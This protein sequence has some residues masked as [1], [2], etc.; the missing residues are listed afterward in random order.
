MDNFIEYLKLK[1]KYF[2]LKLFIFRKNPVLA[3]A[4]LKL[5]EK[6]HIGVWN[7]N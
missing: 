2:I 5:D 1:P 3:R 6:Y 4:I 7:D